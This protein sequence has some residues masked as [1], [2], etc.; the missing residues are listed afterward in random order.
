MYLAVVTHAG[1]LKSMIRLENLVKFLKEHN[2]QS[3]AV[4]NENLYQLVDYKNQFLKNGLKPVIGLKVS[5]DFGQGNT[6]HLLL[7]AKSKTGY[8]NL[9]K[10]SSGIMQK[11]NEIMPSSWLKAYSA[12]VIAV[13]PFNESRWS[14]AV[15][16]V[17]MLKSIYKDNLF[18]G[19]SRMEGISESQEALAMNVSHNYAIEITALHESYYINKEDAFAFKVM[20]AIDNGEK[21]DSF[22]QQEALK[23]LPTPQEMVNMFKDQPQWLQTTNNILNSCNVEFDEYKAHMPEFPLTN[24]ESPKECLHRLAYEGLKLRLGGTIPE[25]YRNRLE[26][27]LGII[28][29]MG[30][31]SYF[32]IVADYMAFAKRENILTGPGRGSSASSLVAYSLYITQV[33]PIQYSLL[34]ERFL[35]P[36]R[37]SLPDIDVD[38]I[39]TRRG[40]VIQYIKERYGQN[41]VAQIITFGT[42]AAKAASRDVGK[43]LRLEEK[44]L[45]QISTLITKSKQ[46]TLPEVY[47]KSKEFQAFVLSS[48][49]NKLWFDTACRLEGLNRNTSTHA[50]GVVLTP[51]PLTNYVPVRK[52]NDGVYLTQWTMNE[53]EGEG[54]LKVDLLGLS[55]LGIIEYVLESIEKT[56]GVKPTLETIPLNDKNT[57]KLLQQGLSD[58]VFQ[59]ESDGMK[60]ALKE[61]KPTA[62]ED[63]IA[64]NALYRPGPMEFISTYAKRKHG[65]EQVIYPHPVLEPILKETYGIIL[66]QEQILLIAQ[67]FAGFTLGEADLLRRAIGKKK[68]EVLEEQESLFV[69]GAVRQGHNETIAKEIYALIVKF[70]EYGF[71]KSHSTAYSFISYQMAFLKANYPS[72][73]YAAQLNR[74]NGD[75]TKVKRILGEM[76]TRNVKVLPI[77]IRYSSSLNT[78][79]NSGVR[80]GLLNVKGIPKTVVD[81]YLK[82]NTQATDLFEYAKSMGGSMKKEVMEKLIKVGAFDF[83]FKQS[84]QTLLASLPQ[85]IEY[86]SM[87]EAFLFGFEKPT[88]IISNEKNDNYKLEQDVIGFSMLSHPVEQL[89][90]EQFQATTEVIREGTRVRIPL[91]VD[92]AKITLTKKK[93]DMAFLEASDEAGSISITIFP[94]LYSNIKPILEVGKIYEVEGKVEMKNNKKQILADKLSVLK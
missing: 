3:C 56:Y 80:L 74:A 94:K 22:Q 6:I 75:A 78:S 25:M 71:P 1:P 77:D 67:K 26:Y 51:Q 66:Y 38:I 11:Q 33:D 49:I 2:V 46:D 29:K 16:E 90:T 8:Q 53:V 83:I 20:R 84:R 58:N 34:F 62:L 87:D 23:H 69:S 32:L 28:S 37:V 9:I 79:E 70:A 55:N 91:L 30:Y 92:N 5:V 72:H 31:D 41:H 73:F 18:I 27:E 4:T 17:Q 85:A 93:E 54:T 81:E 15:N 48:D 42:L 40:E 68:R 88:Y 13:M 76:R 52:G 82:A 19:I 14:N 64:I 39:D 57:F 43:V 10:T 45:K 65:L 21:I 44:D 89:R 86:S 60:K 12:D 24:G 50:A 59:L 35:N 63:I 36:Y 7:Y 61:I 47:K